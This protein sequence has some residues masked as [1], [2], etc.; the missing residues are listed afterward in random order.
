MLDVTQWLI[1]A[2][3]ALSLIAVAEIQKLVLRRVAPKV[4]PAAQSVR[5]T[6]SVT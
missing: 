1:C 4:I 2:A 5:P 3:V 6:A